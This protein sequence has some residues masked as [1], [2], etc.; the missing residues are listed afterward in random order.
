MKS[1]GFL[2]VA[3]AVAFTLFGVCTAQ[4]KEEHGAAASQIP[5]SKYGFGLEIGSDRIAIGITNIYG[6]SRTAIFKD[7]VKNDSDIF[8]NY[9][10]KSL[11]YRPLST[12]VLEPLRPNTPPTALPFGFIRQAKV[13]S[14]A[15]NII[16]L[17]NDVC[18]LNNTGG[19]TTSES[20][21]KKDAFL[22]IY[23]SMLN[24]DILYNHQND[25]EIVQPGF[26]D[27][28]L[29][30]DIQK[31]NKEFTHF[32]REYK[33]FD[34]EIDNEEDSAKRSALK[35]EFKKLQKEIVEKILKISPTFKYD[36]A[37]CFNVE[38]KKNGLV[39]S[40]ALFNAAGRVCKVNVNRMFDANLSSGNLAH[41]VIPVPI[42]LS[43]RALSVLAGGLP[44][45]M[46]LKCYFAPSSFC[47]F[48]GHL[49]VSDALPFSTK[50][51]VSFHIGEETTDACLIKRKTR[52]PPE[53]VAVQ[54]YTYEKA[55]ENLLEDSEGATP[56]GKGAQTPVQEE[57]EEGTGT[58]TISESEIEIYNS[59]DKTV[60]EITEGS[61]DVAAMVKDMLSTYFEVT[62]AEFKAEVGEDL[63]KKAEE[64]KAEEL[65]KSKA[66]AGAQETSGTASTSGLAQ[67]R[68]E[69]PLE[70]SPMCK[71]LPEIN[72]IGEKTSKISVP[73]A[74]L[75]V[76]PFNI[77]EETYSVNAFLYDIVN[78]IKEKIQ[79][80]Y[81]RISHGAAKKAPSSPNESTTADKTAIEWTEVE[82]AKFLAVAQEIKKELDNA[83]SAFPNNLTLKLSTPKIITHTEPT[84]KDAITVSI[85]TA[86]IERIFKKAAEIIYNIA[87]Q[88]AAAS[89]GVYTDEKNSLENMT[90]LLSGDVTLLCG[91]RAHL[92]ADD[93]SI[94]R[95]PS[96][97]VIG[98]SVLGRL[99]ALKEPWRNYM[100]ILEEAVS[101]KNAE[102]LY[103]KNERK[104]FDDSDE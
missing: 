21:I 97:L 64:F 15:S 2:S 101:Y 102:S 91:I 74:D 37:G 16:K 82:T 39:H 85:T 62:D 67:K 13:L 45:D 80:E 56:A 84:G 52:S 103:R 4:S 29:S 28:S 32:Y 63:F 17:M 78:S 94:E 90:V 22:D 98:A 57:R 30:N 83:I 36:W 104:E 10:H 7:Q 70:K 8:F 27:D 12:R 68:T 76:Y 89:T 75:K 54:K 81:T 58:D 99:M 42:H 61:G 40:V 41:F 23:Y 65:K 72:F 88:I 19:A 60:R 35:A 5:I 77:E 96:A 49:A 50:K 79:A 66:K 9:D 69:K 26:V 47:S 6:N 48:I 38:N 3:F 93:T 46:R 34:T 95:D 20:L 14:E 1:N 11:P 87:I 53:S 100:V 73:L 31:L 25:S 55:P 43:D 18:D 51:I 24:F 92:S 71:K 86:D 44:E 59:I 33:K